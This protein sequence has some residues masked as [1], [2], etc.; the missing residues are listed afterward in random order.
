MGVIDK[1]GF[2]FEVEYSVINQTGALHV[3]RGGEFIEEL[4][5]NFEGDRPNPEQIEEIVDGYVGR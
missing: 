1:D 3:Y 5:Y 4:T 2:R